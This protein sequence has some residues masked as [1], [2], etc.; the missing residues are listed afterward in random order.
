MKRFCTSKYRVY[1]KHSNLRINVVNE[2]EVRNEAYQSR[3]ELN[4]LKAL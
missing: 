1:K 4:M 2:W 3:E